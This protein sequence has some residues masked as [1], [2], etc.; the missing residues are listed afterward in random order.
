MCAMCNVQC[1]QQGFITRPPSSW[2]RPAAPVPL[3]LPAQ[4]KHNHSRTD[5]SSFISRALPPLVPFFFLH[6]L[7]SSTNKTLCDIGTTSDYHSHLHLPDVASKRQPK[8]AIQKI[9]TAR[10]L[11]GFNFPSSLSRLFHFHPVGFPLVRYTRTDR[12]I[13]RT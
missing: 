10:F 5:G 9:T 13:S 11:D 2:D 8:T 6:S 3:R 12:P 7:H 4:K 1:Q